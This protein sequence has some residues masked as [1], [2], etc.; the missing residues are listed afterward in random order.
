MKS[1]IR[2]GPA[3][4]LARWMGL[5]H[6][7][8]RRGSDRVESAVHLASFVLLLLSLV[9]GALFGLALYD[10]GARSAAATRATL[11]QASAVVTHGA[12]TDSAYVDH[13]AV[14]A[15]WTYQGVV[16]T[17]MIDVANGT[18]AGSTEPIWVDANGRLAVPPLTAYQIGGDAVFAGLALPFAAMLLLFCADLAV[19]STLNRRR[20]ARWAAEWELIEPGWVQRFRHQ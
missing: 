15:R 19:A 14:P 4:R 13:I 8:L 9:A 5:D 3:R 16:H 2:Y 20:A 18:Q 6:N 11:Y 1:P 17:G 7:P 10:H 12:A